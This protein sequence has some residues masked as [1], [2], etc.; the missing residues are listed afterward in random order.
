MKAFLWILTEPPTGGLAH[1]VTSP[2]YT[3]LLWTKRNSSGKFQ[4]APGS[5]RDKGTQTGRRRRLPSGSEHRRRSA[6]FVWPGFHFL[7]TSVGF[8]PRVVHSPRRSPGFKSILGSKSGALSASR[9]APIRVVG[10][11]RLSFRSQVSQRG[12]LPLM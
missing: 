11:I 5:R 9:R 8:N 6:V 1:F 4:V 10:L 2:Q 12:R 3:R 7:T